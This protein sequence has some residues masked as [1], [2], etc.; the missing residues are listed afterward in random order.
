MTYIVDYGIYFKDNRYQSHTIKVKNCLSELQAKIRLEGYL[1]RKHAN[2]D[3]LVVY[4]CTTDIFD[5]CGIF[6]KGF[7][8]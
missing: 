3:K 6:G 4:K 8:K 1:K 7:K 2:F 5:I